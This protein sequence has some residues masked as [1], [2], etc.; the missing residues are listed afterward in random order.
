MSACKEW[1]PEKSIHD[2]INE[3]SEDK[4]N[5]MAYNNVDAKEKMRLAIE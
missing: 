5:K 1:K 2:S 4:Q 3:C